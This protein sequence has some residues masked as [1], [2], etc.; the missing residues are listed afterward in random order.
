MRFYNLDDR[1]LHEDEAGYSAKRT[2]RK[3]WCELKISKKHQ[4]K[5]V[6]YGLGDKTCS[7]DLTGKTFANW[8]TDAFGFGRDTDPLYRAIPFYYGLNQGI[9]YGIFF[10]NTFPT[11][12]DFNSQ[13]DNVTAFWAEG[14][15]MNYYF[16]HGPQLLDVA[17]AYTRLTGKPELPPIWALGYHQCRWSYYPHSRV[18][19]IADT[20]RAL[21]IPCDAIY[22]DIDYMDGYRCFTWN[23]EHFPEPQNLIAELRQMVFKRW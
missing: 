10:D 21:E 9:A 20:F 14:G 11:H 4:R 18:L 19:E 3:G 12:F 6:Y 1:L 7:P 17:K 22:L 8:C 16:L 5:E 15:E 23:R 13:D 2:I